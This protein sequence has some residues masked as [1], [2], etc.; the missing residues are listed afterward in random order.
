MKSIRLVAMLLCGLAALSPRIP[1]QSV[2]GQIS[3]TVTDAAGSAIAGAQVQL[4]SELT[5]QVRAINTDR[6]GDFLFLDLVPGNYS[7]QIAHPGF[8]THIQHAISVGADEKMAL[9]EIKLAVGE[10]TTS[11]T[12][13]AETAHVATDSS[14]RTIDINSTQVGNT[15]VRGRDWLGVL[16]TLPGVVDLNTH[17]VPGWNSGMPT[18]NGGQT[19]QVLISLDGAASQDS[20][21]FTGTTCTGYMAPSIDAIA[22]VKV[23]V[24]NFTAEYGSRAGGQLVVTVKNGTNQFHGSAFYYYRHETLNANEFFNN[25]SRIQRPLYRYS[26]EGGTFGGPLLIPGTNFNK[27]RTRLFFF[28]SEDY[29]SYLTPGSLNKYTMPTALE[30]Q[31]DFSQTTTTTGTLIKITDPTNKNVQFPGN[32]IP[33]SRISPLGFAMMNLF[34]LPFTTDPTGQRQYNAIYQF[35]RHDPHEDRILRLDYNV[36]PKTQAFVRL[37][38]DYQADRGIGATLNSTGGWGQ[39]P[40]DY[41]IQSAGVVLTVIHTFRPN[42]INEFTTGV[43]R[44]HQSVAVEDQTSLA[45]NQLAALK[46]PSG[47]S[48]TVPKLYQGNESGL[49]TNLIPN[50]RFS[51][52]NPQSAGQGVTNAP[53]FTFDARFPFDGTDQ[54]ETTTDTVSWIKD[55]HTVKFGFYVERM[56]RNV[57]VYS[58]YNTNGSFYFGSDKASA[59]DTGYAYSN[60]LTGAVQAYGEDSRRF[61]NHARYNQIEWFAQDSWRASRRLTIDYGMRFQFLGTLSSAGTTMGFFDATKYNT[62]T[63]GTLL[64]PAVVN[65]QNVSEN[66]KTGATYL[67]ARQDFFDPLSYS[68]NGSPYSGMV[69]FQDQV[70]NNPGLSYGPRIGFGLDVFGNGKTALRGGF[71]IFHDRAF[72]V[73]TDGAT[74][75]GVGPISAPPTFQAPIYYNTN[76]SQMVGAQGFLS[77]A[78]VFTGRDYKNPGVYNWSF[79]IQHDLGKGLIVDVAYVGNIVHHQFK[80]IDLNGIAP[81]TL[82][83][84]T[85]GV[86]TAYLDPTNKAAFY[87]ANLLRPYAGYGAINYSCSCGEAN[88]NSLQTQF[89]RRFG[90]R[91]QFSANWTWSKTMSY[92]RNAWTSDY[93]AY[94]EVSADRPQVVNLNYSY[95]IPDGSRFWKNAVT[96]AVL[97]GWHFNGV[98]KLM[99]GTP[100]TVG[101]SANS[102][103]IG[104][105]TGTT[106]GGIPFRCQMATSNPFL[107]SGSPLPKNAPIG[108]YYPLNPANYTLPGPNTLGIGNTPPTLFLGPG[109]EN[110]DF[111]LFKDIRID[112]KG[113]TLELRAE[114]FNVL[115]HF[116][117]GNP[118]TSLTLNYSNGANT[119]ANFGSITSAVGQARHLAL[120]AKFRF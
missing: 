56:A 81:Y 67:Q 9:H 74:S 14:D 84:P 94:A 95:Q 27:S 112:E 20:G 59:F 62:A 21:C 58:L 71:G 32:I 54:V 7:V 3:G 1:A 23:M 18:I 96:K 64:F 99:S 11:V 39:M 4:T 77:T 44:A 38:N 36:G 82:W 115:N 86:N 88:Y 51:T 12:V 109:F 42:L 40:T 50:I 79:G 73:D 24:S 28:F 53:S 66:L 80:Q 5:K 87:T 90:R 6:S 69:Q 93:L 22:Q 119:N 76:F 34:P 91:L 46:G 65:G 104:Y 108:L 33:A 114:A 70:F 68:A 52:L 72:G 111:S 15:P 48:V 19:G 8:K 107:A 43:N 57:S 10:V 41:G 45:A 13:V 75:A 110:F 98:T 25:A 47:E 118:N 102:A 37:M 30:R 26:N 89:N 103:P 83:T 116:N 101:C 2:T 100:L 97:D 60:L 78:T 17:D 105:W 106:T 85:S 31:G 29:L 16:E 49:M 120:A 61:A 55:K 35:S 117:P 63:A 92:T 113:K